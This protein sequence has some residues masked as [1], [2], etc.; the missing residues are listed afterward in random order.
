M[1]EIIND[2]MMYQTLPIEIQD[3]IGFIIESAME[4]NL[5]ISIRGENIE[6]D[7]DSLGEALPD[8]QKDH[9]L[10]FRGCC[11]LPVEAVVQY[12]NG[13]GEMLFGNPK[14]LHD[15]LFADD[16]DYDETPPF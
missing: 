1:Y 5:M 8:G 15:I 10:E 6:S 3:E 9:R 14:E 16:E 13:G 11:A 4:H 12:H 7:T 2:K